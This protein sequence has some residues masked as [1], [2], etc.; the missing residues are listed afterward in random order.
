MSFKKFEGRKNNV[1]IVQKF[2]FLFFSR[3]AYLICHISIIG[4]FL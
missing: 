1:S 4:I 3:S 2:F